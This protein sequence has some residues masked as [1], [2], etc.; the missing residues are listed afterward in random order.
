MPHPY[1]LFLSNPL[2][3][4]RERQRQR[5]IV[6]SIYNYLHILQKVIYAV[7]LKQFSRPLKLC[8]ESIALF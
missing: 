5:L 1:F 6:D 3:V 4:Q 2:K 7:V 8:F